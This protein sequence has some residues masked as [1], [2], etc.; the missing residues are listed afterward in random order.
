MIFIL[1]YKNLDT[2]KIAL[3]KLKMKISHQEDLILR[4]TSSLSPD[5]YPHLRSIYVGN[6]GYCLTIQD[7]T[8]ISTPMVE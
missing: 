7:K 8:W 5:D 3:P 6:N 1:K 4:I 2:I